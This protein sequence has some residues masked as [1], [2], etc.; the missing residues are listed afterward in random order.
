MWYPHKIHRLT[1]AVMKNNYYELIRD[2]KEETHI[3]TSELLK[4]FEKDGKA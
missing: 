1:L 2:Y 4:E 3:E